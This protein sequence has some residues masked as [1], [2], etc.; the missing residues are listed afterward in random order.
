[1]IDLHTHTTFSDGRC[2]PEELV[3]RA[4]AAGVRVLAVTDHDTVAGCAP[5]ADA[6]VRAKIT[7]VPG[8]EITAVVDGADVHVLGYFVQ[9][10]APA[11]QAFLA[12]QR[13]R[14][15]DRVREM[16]ARLVPHGIEL[17][18][19]AI[20]QPGIAD[21]TKAVGRPWIARAL[22][23]LGHV[24]NVSEAFN[25]WLSRGRPAFVPRIGAEPEEVFSRIHT[26]GG[27]ASLAHPVLVKHDEWLPPFA[28]SGLDALE[29]FHSDH[30]ETTTAH[31]LALANTLRLGVSGGSDY[32]ADDAHGGGPPGKVSLPQEYYEGLLRLRAARRA[33][34]SSAGSATSS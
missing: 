20:L 1:V 26:A 16:V 29:V 19:D 32:H 25:R 4:A 17:D 9:A 23:E 5:A 27:I 14:R 18:A 8:I 21:S 12:E 34:A 31:Y 22:V 28:Q 6:C 15:V 24:P 3:A 30:D 11:L 10:D 2:T 33:S 13:Q 7:F